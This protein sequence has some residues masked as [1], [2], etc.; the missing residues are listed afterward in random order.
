MVISCTV[1]R[2]FHWKREKAF[3]SSETSKNG[4]LANGNPAVPPVA[5]KLFRCR[6]IGKNGHFG[7]FKAGRFAGSE[8]TLSQAT[9]RPKIFT[10]RKGTR[11]F[12][13]R[14]EKFFKYRNVGKMV[15]SLRV[16][17]PFRR[18][19]END[20]SSSETSKTV[21]SRK[22]NRPFSRWRG[23]FFQVPKLRKKWSFRER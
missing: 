21:T 8:K 17:R 12:P 2:L 10:S 7:N 5:R 6:N 3:S 20:F 18:K 22:G 11:S 19:G 23:N 13:R 1:S 4:H 14:Q 15:I 9:K 16:S